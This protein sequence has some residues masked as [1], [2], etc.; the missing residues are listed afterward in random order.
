[1]LPE[2][3]P[4][5]ANFVRC[6][7]DGTTLYV[8]GHGPVS[9]DDMI[10]G[11]V[12]S[13]LTLEQGRHAARLTGLALLASMQA[14]LGSLDRVERVVK[15]LGMVE[16]RPRL[17]PHAG[18]DQR[19]LGSVRRHLRRGRTT[20][21]QRGR[22]GGAARGH[23]R[24]DR[25]DRP[26]PRLSGLPTP[27][28]GSMP[29]ARQQAGATRRCFMFVQVIEGKT[30]NPEGLRTQFDKWVAELQPGAKGYVGT[31]AGV[32]ADG[33]VVAFAR[34]ESEE[35]RGRTATAP[36]KARGGRRPRRCS[37]VQSSSASPA[38]SRTSLPVGRTTPASCSS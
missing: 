30:S 15:L 13:D 17:R 19:L 2:V 29:R 31:T 32:A 25:G 34:F 7:L 37:T 23:R 33:R 4:P 28:R 18:G 3:R 16:R 8:S 5:V 21:S 11:K 10:R 12:G 27:R 35:Q 1:M 36:S 20:R 14:E 22:L 24:R 6:V 9:G 26:H 38:T